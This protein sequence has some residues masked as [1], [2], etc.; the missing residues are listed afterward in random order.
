MQCPI[1]GNELI[2]KIDNNGN[3]VLR[4]NNGHSFDISKYGYVNLL[5]SKTNSGDNKEMVL[6][7]HNFLKKDYY[8][9]LALKLKTIINDLKIKNLLDIG[10]GEGYY[11]RLINDK[12]INIYGL[13]ISKEA[14]LKA[15]K[16]NSDIQ[17]VVASSNKLP[18]EDNYFDCVMS[19]FSPIYPKEAKRVS[20]KYLIK[21][22]PNKDH[23]KELRQE[24]Y[25]NVRD[26]KILKEEID[27]FN[28]IDE[29]TLDYKMNV[30]DVN[31]LFKMTPY[32][33]TTHNNYEIK[34]NEMEISFSFIIR[35]YKVY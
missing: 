28:L 5:P 1:C 24:L 33:Y 13:D 11:D 31:E 18:F 8:L 14:I 17:Y 16:L 10:C 12:T 6:A 9:K 7:R 20:S 26:N 34:F 32:F 35:I 2:K 22:I 19:I 25:E 27:G 29:I 21:V 3:N 23:L 15:A 4:C 30:V